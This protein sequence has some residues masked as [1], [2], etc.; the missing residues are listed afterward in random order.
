[1]S[2]QKKIRSKGDCR[3]ADASFDKIVEQRWNSHLQ[4]MRPELAKTKS[5]GGTYY[6]A[7]LQSVELC[8]GQDDE[9]QSAERNASETTH[10]KNE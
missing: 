7:W 9:R 6:K 3:E 1:M 10:E 8:D 4:A 5:V 2:V